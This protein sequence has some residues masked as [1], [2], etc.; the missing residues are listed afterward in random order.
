MS[1]LSYFIR[2]PPAARRAYSVFSKPGGGRYFNS[3]K[4]SKVVA[5]SATNNKP[6]ADTNDGSS[7]D[8]GSSQTPN[9]NSSQLNAAEAQQGQ[10]FSSLS[11][12]MTNAIPQPHPPINPQDL[13]V[14]QFF[15][16]HRPLL[17]ISQPTVSIFESM[18]FANFPPQTPKIS[19]NEGDRIGMGSMFDDPPEASAE[20]DADAARQLARA[21]VVNRVGAS[22]AWEDTLRRLGLDPAEGRV[23]EVKMAEAEYEMF[24]DSVKR[25]RRKKMK[26][27]K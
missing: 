13:R 25:K 22:L 3:A 11:F 18:P 6:K 9:G 24:M 8:V 10:S 26:T 20:S 19:E 17:T 21:L 2:P 1:M 23:E 27:H 16:L 7:E 12:P 5:Q 4:P 15:S 14:H